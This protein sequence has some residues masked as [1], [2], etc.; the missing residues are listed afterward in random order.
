MK[1]F[2]FTLLIAVG[3]SGTMFAKTA[4]L[5]TFNEEA[6]EAEFASFDNIVN[7]NN[8]EN[9]FSVFYKY[10]ISVDDGSIFSSGSYWVGFGTTC[11]FAGGGGCILLTIGAVAGSC[12]GL[13]ASVLFSYIFF[14]GDKDDLK[15]SF[16]GSLSSAL[17]TTISFFTLEVL[18][19]ASI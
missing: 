15:K 4:D 19:Y 3:F 1:Q 5:F 12:V 8:V 2:I 13:G 14:D 7:N 9:Y 10:G 16:W 6:I 18:Y 11:L 17:I